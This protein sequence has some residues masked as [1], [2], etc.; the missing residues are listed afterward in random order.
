MARCSEKGCKNGATERRVIGTVGE[1]TKTRPVCKDHL[2]GGVG[3]QDLGVVKDFYS[4]FRIIV[5]NGPPGVGKD[6]LISQC[7]ESLNFNGRAF[8]LSYKLTLY[9]AVAERFGLDVD[10]VKQTNENR[11]TKEVPME[12]FGGVSVRQALINES[13][14]ELKVKYGVKG[15]AR[16]TIEDLLEVIKPEAHEPI[17]LLNPDGGFNAE[18]DFIKER[19]GLTDKQIFVVRL[20]KLHCSFKGDSREFIRNPNLIV[21]NDQSKQWLKDQTYK[22][23][24]D[25]LDN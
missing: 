19:L 18:L 1:A 22:P 16:I 14:D 7:I 24:Q 11:D 20:L 2:I 17:L 25:W 3:K 8:I 12:C 4:G 21:H 13:E 23:I 10:F 15:V 6:T 5:A 9:K